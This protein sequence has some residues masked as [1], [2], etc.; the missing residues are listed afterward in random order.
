LRLPVLVGKAALATQDGGFL[1]CG[2]R[3]ILRGLGRKPDYMVKLQQP[4]LY[5]LGLDERKRL[6]ANMACAL[7]T[8]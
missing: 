8:Q 2:H 1:T 5:G 7:L 6:S 3:A 4:R